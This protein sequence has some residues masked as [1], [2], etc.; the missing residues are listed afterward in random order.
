MLFVPFPMSIQQQPKTQFVRGIN[1]RNVLHCFYNPFLV[2]CCFSLHSVICMFEKHIT[3]RESHHKILLNKG[4]KASRRPDCKYCKV[5][6]LGPTSS[7]H[8]IVTCS[9]RLVYV[10]LLA[11]SACG[12]MASLPNTASG[13]TKL[14]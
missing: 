12:A 9:S 8:I 4:I 2:T 1:E 6:Y 14:A 10:L 13:C 11:I 5:K 3:N 7:H